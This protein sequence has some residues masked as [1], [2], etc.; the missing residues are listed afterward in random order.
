MISDESRL[1]SSAARSERM[2]IVTLSKS[3]R[4]AALGACWEGGGGGVLEA[5]AVACGPLYRGATGARIGA[6]LVWRWF[7]GCGGCGLVN[8]WRLAQHGP[9]A[10]HWPH[11]EEHGDRWRSKTWIAT[12]D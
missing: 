4:S 5:A 2:P 12:A 1:L 7:I 10:A 9:R 6:C 11:P 8:R 3:I